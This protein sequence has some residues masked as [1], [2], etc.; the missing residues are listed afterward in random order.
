ME[1]CSHKLAAVGVTYAEHLY[2]GLSKTEIAATLTTLG[3]LASTQNAPAGYAFQT[4]HASWIRDGA[5]AVQC[6]TTGYSSVIFIRR[7]K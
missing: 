4:G 2:L 1:D 5:V 6:T 7:N 3:Q